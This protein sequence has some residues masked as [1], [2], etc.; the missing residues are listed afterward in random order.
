MQQV[1]ALSVTHSTAAPAFLGQLDRFVEAVASASDRDLLAASRCVGWAVVEVVVHVR[2]GLQEMLGGIGAVTDRVPD[3]DAATYWRDYR[4]SD[5][6]SDEVDAIL[7]TRRTASA[8]RRPRNALEHLRMT[9]D[10][11]RGAVTRMTPAPVSFQG[12]VLASGDFLA[13]WAVELAVHHL[14]LGR[15]VHF[16]SPTA[17]SL[18]LGRATVEAL[19][20]APLPPQWSDEVCLLAGAGRTPPPETPRLPGGIRPLPVLG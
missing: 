1:G 5:P 9:A 19:A 18:G 15:D 7:W 6:G 12:H 10:T 8:Y 3:Q 2:V 20:G 4:A 13:T 16:G 11:V 14:D 17:D